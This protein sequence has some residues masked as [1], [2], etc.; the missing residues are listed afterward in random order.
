MDRFVAAYLSRSEAIN[1]LKADAFV[2][3]EDYFSRAAPTHER[4]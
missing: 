3:K 4:W 2:S 1:A